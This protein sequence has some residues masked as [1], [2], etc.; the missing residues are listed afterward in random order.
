MTGGNAV[1]IKAN[2]D[3]GAA[4]C[5]PS[6]GKAAVRANRRPARSMALRAAAN[7][8]HGW[9]AP[10]STVSSWP[11]MKAEAS[12]ARNMTTPIRSSG[13][14]GRRLC[15]IDHAQRAG[16]ELHDARHA[17]GLDVLEGGKQILHCLGADAPFQRPVD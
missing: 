10:P 14:C 7:G 2:C 6:A 5:Q 4:I 13:T 1:R 11:V 15:W 17:V 16:P 9:V 3:R 8:T 12:E